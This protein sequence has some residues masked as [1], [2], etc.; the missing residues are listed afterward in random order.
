M[1][2]LKTLTIHYNGQGSRQTSSDPLGND[3][4]SQL[5]QGQEVSLI[6]KP[7]KIFPNST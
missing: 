2:L 7:V 4:F 1:H 6:G 5:K 3:P